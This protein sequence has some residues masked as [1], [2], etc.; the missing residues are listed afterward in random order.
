MSDE[1]TIEYYFD[2]DTGETFMQVEGL[3]PQKCEN[4]TKELIAA[5]GMKDAKV[6]K[7]QEIRYEGDGGS[8][9]DSV[10]RG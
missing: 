5:M 2:P 10:D 3:P 4:V 8:R 9:G 6:K 1:G 7:T